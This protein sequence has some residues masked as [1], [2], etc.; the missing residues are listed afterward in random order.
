MELFVTAYTSERVAIVIGGA[1]GVGEAVVER[2]ARDRWKVI[3]ADSN[4]NERLAQQ[5]AD[6]LRATGREVSAETVDIGDEGEV[7]ALIEATAEFEGGLHAIVDCTNTAAAQ[8]ASLLKYGANEISNTGGGTIVLVN[9]SDAV[10]Q[11][12]ADHSTA[13]V[14]VHC[15]HTTTFR[16]LDEVSALLPSA[17]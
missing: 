12:A 7:A 1:S 4:D 6:N 14:R 13:G 8:L 16:I 3:V 11:L 5:V 15:L 10:S 9:D 17:S 2:M